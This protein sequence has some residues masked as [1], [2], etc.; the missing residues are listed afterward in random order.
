MAVLPWVTVMVELSLRAGYLAFVISDPP[1]SPMFGLRGFLLCNKPV[2][3][4]RLLAFNWVQVIRNTDE[5]LE[6]ISGRN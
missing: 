5:R 1:S 3:L 4:P 2:R 6:G